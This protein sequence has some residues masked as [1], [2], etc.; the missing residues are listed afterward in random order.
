MLIRYHPAFVRMLVVLCQKILYASPPSPNLTQESSR[1]TIIVSV[2]PSKNKLKKEVEMLNAASLDRM[3]GSCKCSNCNKDGKMKMC[4]GCHMV[5]Y[6]G[7]ECQK[8]QWAAHK[9]FCKRK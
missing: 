6:C 1:S 5:G 2:A 8:A 3:L 4:S 9:A 7:A